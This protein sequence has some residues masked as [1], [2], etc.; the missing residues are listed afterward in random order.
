MRTLAIVAVLAAAAAAD[1]KPP[2]AESAAVKSCLA[3]LEKTRKGTYQDCVG[4]AVALCLDGPETMAVFD[5]Q[6][7]ETAIWDEL[8]N[9]R[10]RELSR[11][12]PKPVFDELREVQRAWVKY[13][14]AKCTFNQSLPD[15]GET[16]RDKMEHGCRLDETAR[17]ANELEQLRAWRAKLAK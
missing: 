12:L 17:R 13:R 3:E 11:L 2:A 9:A 8:L 1:E 10:Y 6:I 14:D 16:G 5:C 15:V 4:K 7:H